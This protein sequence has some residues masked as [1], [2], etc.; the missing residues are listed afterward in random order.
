MQ[1]WQSCHTSSWY[2]ALGC[3]KHSRDTMQATIAKSANSTLI[4]GDEKLVDRDIL[5]WACS[6]RCWVTSKQTL[7][8][9]C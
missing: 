6:G 4:A 7:A 8:L 5:L 2:A 1:M 3:A 9:T